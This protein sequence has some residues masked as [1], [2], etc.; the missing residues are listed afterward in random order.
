[1]SLGKKRYIIDKG[2]VKERVEQTR[3]QG[4]I[5]PG[6]DEA[7]LSEPFRN[8]TGLY[9]L[10]DPINNTVSYGDTENSQFSS[11]TVAETITDE[12][13]ITQYIKFEKGFFERPTA[14]ALAFAN[15]AESDTFSDHYFEYYT[16]FNSDEQLILNSNLMSLN[17]SVDF[18][19]NFYSKNYE[20]GLS[21]LSINGMKKLTNV[22]DLYN[23]ITV[24]N[25]SAIPE[26]VLLSPTLLESLSEVSV[27]KDDI[28]MYT[29]I[30]FDTDGVSSFSEQIEDINYT[31]ALYLQ[32]FY[33]M[34]F[35][36]PGTD[37]ISQESFYSISEFVAD[38]GS[39]VSG[40]SDDTYTLLNLQAALKGLDMSYID[41]SAVPSTK[42]YDLDNTEKGFS[43]DS[44]AMS[45]SAFFAKVILNGILNNMASDHM[46]SYTDILDGKEAFQ[47]TLFYEIQ[48]TEGGQQIERWMIP[49][50][51]DTSINNLIDKK[52]R[53]DKQ[54]SYTFYAYK[55]VFGSEYTFSNF[56]FTEEPGAFATAPAV[57]FVN[58]QVTTTPSIKIIKVPYFISSGHMIDSPSIAPEVQ[59]I[60]YRGIDDKLLF[61]FNSPIGEY[62]KDPIIVSDSD[63]S[64][65]AKY[66]QKAA[67]SPADPITYKTDDVPTEFGVYRIGSKPSS[68]EDF[69]NNLRYTLSTSHS[70]YHISY[71]FN[72]S[73]VDS[74]K[75]NTKYYYMFRSIDVHGN[76]SDVSNIYQVELINDGLSIYLEYSILELEEDKNTQPTRSFRKLL[77]IQPAFQQIVFDKT[78]LEGYNSAYDVQSGQYLG[79]A[80]DPVWKK[81]FKIRLISKK[82]GRKIDLNLKFKQRVRPSEKETSDVILGAEGVD[83]PT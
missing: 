4:E 70:S 27:A 24:I 42:I 55:A 18:V 35:S 56:T 67:L 81:R 43:D 52:V 58:F 15:Q 1:M 34:G 57:P 26:D 82:T 19:Y 64:I 12:Q 73:V 61:L 28:P 6:T 72:A 11:Y 14:D 38:D 68:Y 13:S 20:E 3:G 41:L 46:R 23:S 69:D 33:S 78:K 47:E 77:Q 25:E 48:K 76:Y 49:N 50:T 31:I 37:L 65:L 74:L 32:I 2:A 9:W 83:V 66:R 21:G 5:A 60:P 8:G 29:D 62:E 79:V 75:S 71:T 36:A 59:I 54:Y 40:V 22:F 10:V 17:G 39:V 44:D 80:D 51:V 30:S 45:V 16:P 63:R 7:E 53:Y